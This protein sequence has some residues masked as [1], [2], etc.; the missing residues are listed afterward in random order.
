[1]LEDKKISRRGI[2]KTWG[3]AAALMGAGSFIHSGSLKAAAKKQTKQV[4]GFYRFYTWRF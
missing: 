3:T 4:P 2:L 1:M